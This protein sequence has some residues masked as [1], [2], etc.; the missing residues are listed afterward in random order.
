MHKEES[1]EIHKVN[2]ERPYAVFEFQ[3]VLDKRPDFCLPLFIKWCEFKVHIQVVVDKIL[4]VSIRVFNKISLQSFGDSLFFLVHRKPIKLDSQ[5]L[6]HK[7]FDC[8]DFSLQ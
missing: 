1:V 2:I 7:F 3:H 8:R 6:N 5:F 4:V